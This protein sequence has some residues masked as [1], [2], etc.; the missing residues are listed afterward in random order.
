MIDD[1]EKEPETEKKVCP[2]FSANVSE[3]A[4]HVPKKQALYSDRIRNIAHFTETAGTRYLPKLS[5][6]RDLRLIPKS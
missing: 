5:E 6:K 4:G 3:D 2:E 1:K